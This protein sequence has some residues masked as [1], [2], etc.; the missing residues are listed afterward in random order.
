MNIALVTVFIALI[1]ILYQ[2]Y[3]QAKN[4]LEPVLWKHPNCLP[5]LIGRLAPNTVLQ[6]IRKIRH[7]FKGPE[8]LVIDVQSEEGY[9]YASFADGSIGK[10]DQHGKFDT[11]I[12][13]VGSFLRDYNTSM[14]EKFQEE[15][16]QASWKGKLAWNTTAEKSC[17]RPLGLRIRYNVSSL[18]CV[19]MKY[20]D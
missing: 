17:G 8:S 18:L 12:L 4:V 15:C 11:R 10:F 3:D 20:C 7:D 9:V 13:H 2:F 5:P 1:A 19:S 16:K 14:T 6:N